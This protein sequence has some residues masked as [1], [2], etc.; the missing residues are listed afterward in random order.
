MRN[1]LKKLFETNLAIKKIIVQIVLIAIICMCVF[2]F[3]GKLS[4]IDA[5]GPYWAVF[6]NA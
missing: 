6:L 1:I 5:G 2:V 4:K 3:K